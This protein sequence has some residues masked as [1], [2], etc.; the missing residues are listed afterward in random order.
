MAKK[1]KKADVLD[2]GNDKVAE[3]KRF[4]IWSTIPYKIKKLSLEEMQAIGVST[5]YLE[6]A[7]QPYQKDFAKAFQM[8][9]AT[10]SAWKKKSEY[11]DDVDVELK[12]SIK[13]EYAPRIDH[14]F[15]E[16][17]EKNADAGRVKLW[18]Q[19]Y[20]GYE[21]A[22]TINHN[23]KINETHNSLELLTIDGIFSLVVA[24]LCNKG[25]LDL[26]P[27]M[28]R[29]QRGFYGRANERLGITDPV[30]M[31]EWQDAQVLPSK[32]QY[33]FEEIAEKHGSKDISGEG[34][35]SRITIGKEKSKAD[36]KALLSGKG[37]SK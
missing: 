13:R 23:V 32:M 25:S 22:S 20:E 10:L 5:E 29:L 35:V 36:L 34:E 31:S 3:Y 18:K 11:W 33:D 1:I 28:E 7:N 19:L 27:V 16:A 15:S 26:I 9:E 37:K 14:A 12:Q 30:E 2:K 17:T 4:V 8:T 6:F 21:E 24:K